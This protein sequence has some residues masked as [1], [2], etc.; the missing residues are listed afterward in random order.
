MGVDGLNGAV[1]ATTTPASLAQVYRF[2]G[3][4]LGAIARQPDL[5]VASN[6]VTATFPARSLTLLVIPRH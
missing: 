6:G 4:N 5:A 3:S 2:S 1:A